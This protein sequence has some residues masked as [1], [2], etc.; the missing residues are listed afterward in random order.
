MFLVLIKKIYILLIVVSLISSCSTGTKLNRKIF[1]K[2]KEPVAVCES[3]QA[4]TDEQADADMNKDIYAL[5]QSIE[6]SLVFREKMTAAFKDVDF[7]NIPDKPFSPDKIDR[8][9][10]GL[11]REVDLMR[12][13]F[14][15]VVKHGCWVK[16]QEY[17]VTDQV[18][19]KGNLLVLATMMSLY[20]DYS[21]VIVVLNKNDRLRRFINRADAG[22][23]REDYLLEGLTDMFVNHDLLSYVTDLIERYHQHED[24]VKELA[25]EDDTI[26]YLS[27]VIEK[28]KSY[29]V[30]LKMDYFDAANHRRSVRHN[31]TADTLN[32]I[33]RSSMNLLSEGFSTAIGSFEDRKGLLYNDEQL[34]KTISAQ[35]QIGDILLE[36]TPFRL[37]DSM[38]PGHWGHAALWIG[39]EQE[40]KNLGLWEHPLVSR[41]HEEIRRGELIAESLRTGTT[42]S[43]MTHF[44]NIDDIAVLRSRKPLSD[45]EMRETIILGLRQIGKEYDFNFDVETTDKIVCSQLVYLAYSKIEWP[46]ESVVGRYTIS[47][48]NIAN[49]ALNNGPF[50]LKLFYHEGKRVEKNELELMEN[51]MKQE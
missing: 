45:Q 6:R 46:T 42:L 33:G 5:Q 26:K 20:D 28:S 37:T 7:D 21:A 29:P 35:L 47:P 3:Y 31:V 22:Y 40:L 18:K 11:Q 27:Q 4:M 14:E 12:P 17:T 2:D 13:M 23:D 51:L 41:Y 19:L 25:L 32:E 43:S 49:K 10:K 36:K 24:A 30:M 39:T 15:M 8:L 34:V 38:I 48:D 16:H 50:E 9:S 1:F 44:L